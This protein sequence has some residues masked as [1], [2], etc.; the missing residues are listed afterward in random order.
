MLFFRVF[1]LFSSP[2]YTPL[3]SLFVSSLSEPCFEPPKTLDRSLVCVFLASFFFPMFVVSSTIFSLVFVSPQI[4]TK[5]ILATYPNL[6]PFEYSQGDSSR[7]R[8][9]PSRES[10]KSLLFPQHARLDSTMSRV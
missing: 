1:R 7:L 5:Y 8:C 2:L 9:G 4:V 3:L 10:L 6:F